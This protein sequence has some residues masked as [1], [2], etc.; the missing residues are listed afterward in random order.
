M[1]QLEHRLPK[2][3]VERGGASHLTMSYSRSIHSS[4]CSQATDLRPAAS[5]ANVSQAAQERADVFDGAVHGQ[6]G[7]TATQDYSRRAY[8]KDFVKVG[9][10]GACLQN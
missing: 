3:P 5:L 10:R 4:F 2:L 6:D 7:V 9:W 8:Y 1:A